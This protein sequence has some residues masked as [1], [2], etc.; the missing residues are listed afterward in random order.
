MAEG[1]DVRTGSKVPL[2]EL[3]YIFGVH[4]DKEMNHRVEE[5]TK[6]LGGLRGI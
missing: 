3:I 2:L 5:G 1:R 4:G 6:V